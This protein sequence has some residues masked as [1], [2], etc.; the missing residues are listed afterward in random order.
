MNRIIKI[1]SNLF[2]FLLCSFSLWGQNNITLSGKIVDKTDNEPI[3][4]GTVELLNTKDSTVIAGIVTNSN[5]LF[6][7]KNISAG[8]YI[9][10]VTYIGYKTLV[11]RIGVKPDS[12]AVNIGTLYLE[13][14]DILLQE[15]IIEGKKP[16]IIVKNDTI[17][18]D[19]ASYKVSENAAVEDLL[20]KMPGVEID[21]EG[22]ITVN[23][24]EVKKIRVDNKEFFSDD[25]Q[26]A[27]KNLPA[28]IV[29]KVQVLD[30]K[31]DMA[32][33]TGFDDGEEETIINLTI[34]PGMKK[35]TMGNA[36][37]GTGA[38]I[39]TDHDSRYQGAA[40][41]NHMKDNDRYT[42]II[43]TNNNN[44]MG[45]AD[46]GVNRFSGMRMR[47]GGAGGISKTTNFM[48][49]MNKE[50]SSVLSLNSDIRYTG[51]N[52]LSISKIVELTTLS[53]DISQIDTTQ[54]NTNYRSNNIAANFTLEW[55]P[56]TANI[57]T[58]R[59]NLS[60]NTSHSNEEEI[61]N[62]Y[63]Y[64]NMSKMFDSNSQ[65]ENKG[66]GYSLSGTLDYSHK[67]GKQGRVFSTNIKGSYN[68]SYSWENNRTN[69]KK[70]MELSNLPENLNQHSENDNNIYN[71]QSTFSYVEP[72]GKN[73]FLQLLYRI[74]YYNTQGINSTYDLNEPEQLAMRNDSLSRSTMRYSTEQRLG[75][76][77]KTVREK[78]NYTIGFNIDPTHSVNETYQ[79]SHENLI[80]E[81]YHYNSRITNTIGDS[82]ISSIRQDVINFSPVINF[83]YIFGPRTNLRI[84]YE[85]E[86]NQPSAAQLRDYTDMSRPTNWVKGNPNLKPGYSNSLRIRFS[87]YIAATQLMYN[88]GLN[89]SL[90]FN[91]ITSVTQ[92]QGDGIRLTTYENIN[93]NWNIQSR[94]MFNMPLRNKKIS[95]SNFGAAGYRKQN[96][97]ISNPEAEK[98]QNTM[99]NLNIMDNASINY[100]SDLFDIGINASVNY[101]SIAYAMKINDN[102]K[103]YNLGLG[104]Y[105]TWYLP[106]KITIDSDINWIKRIG[107]ASEFNLPE[108]LW[109]TAVTKQLFNKKI[110]TGSLK[111][112][113]FDILQK[114]KNISSTY[115]TNGFRTSEENMMPSYFMCSFIY[116][117]TVFPKSSSVTEDEL[118]RGIQR[119]W[120]G[121]PGSEGGR[122]NSF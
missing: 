75:L 90:S 48:L 59:P 29:D 60:F 72:L 105:T 57:L 111:L 56:D 11:Q 109:N 10:R 122:R 16:E 26:V 28:E 52:R 64:G 45:A 15:A 30:K 102:Q 91:D 78:Y 17:E 14:N 79:P 66:K 99:R 110:G 13:T 58:F 116:K 42:L 36:L 104:G 112:Q 7:F 93:G 107:Y 118:R 33:M 61:L 53:K 117:F 24:K 83:N 115:T 80:V 70:Y 32:R 55:K 34:R 120:T 51:S 88:I 121:G 119:R 3:I 35:G 31:S 43:G 47:R 41:I 103:T 81:P 19:A 1:I 46:L 84:D 63:N 8:R 54:T 21:K 50:F 89:G 9:I 100:R 69:V 87:K 67:F 74:S 68:D 40:F 86:T 2:F 97:Y 22:K 20:K 101:N 108:L 25:P 92:T 37:L 6:S 98:L 12:D 94:G 39:Q 23:G 82:L 113:I 49:S 114:R 4:A 73:H 18:Y 44:N 27:S 65:S 85:G 106:Y 96:S 76:S 62:Q 71:F 95:I 5:G 77:F 38:D